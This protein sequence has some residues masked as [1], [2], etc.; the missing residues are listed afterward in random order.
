MSMINIVQGTW[1]VC[2]CFTHCVLFDTAVWWCSI[3]SRQS[4]SIL[5]RPKDTNQNAFSQPV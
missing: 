1:V 3:N 2:C 4:A 5:Q